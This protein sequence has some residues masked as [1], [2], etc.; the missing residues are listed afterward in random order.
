[1]NNVLSIGVVCK[2]K[3]MIGKMFLRFDFRFTSKYGEHKHKFIILK[4]WRVQMIGLQC[5]KFKDH[6][7]RFI[8]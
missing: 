3:L 1:M 5:E 4:I 7:H 8:I 6:K 2:I